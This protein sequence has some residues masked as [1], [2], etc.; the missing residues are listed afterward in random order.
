MINI[1]TIPAIRFKMIRK[2]AIG[3]LI[4]LQEHGSGRITNRQQTAH[5]T[6][7]VMLIDCNSI[8]VAL[9]LMQKVSFYLYFS[10]NTND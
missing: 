2:T 8:H 3:F 4:F 10:F 6:T 1:F 7:A 5:K 9:K